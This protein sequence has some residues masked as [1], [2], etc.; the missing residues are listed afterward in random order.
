M[1]EEKPKFDISKEELD[2]INKDITKAR[3][4]LVSKEMEDKIAKIKEEVRIEAEKEFLINEKI[5]QSEQEKAELQKK[6]DDIQKASAEELEKLK[7]KVD[8]L[9]SSKAP[10]KTEDPFSKKNSSGDA[11]IDS[12]NE[13]KVQDFEEASA[14]S[15]WG[16][17]AYEDMKRN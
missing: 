6:I 1:P 17:E 5:K 3:E 9:I 11:G 16:D 8:E 14:R 2:A 15:F 7:S 4:G 12:W 13:E 10:V